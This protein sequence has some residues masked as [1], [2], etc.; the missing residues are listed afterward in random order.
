MRRR[1][2]FNILAFFSTI[3][4]IHARPVAGT[5]KGAMRA[6]TVGQSGKHLG[7]K[8][9]KLYVLFVV[10]VLIISTSC[11]LPGSNTSFT[12]TPALASIRGILWHDICKYSGGEAGAPVV[13]GQ[14]CV[15]WGATTD[16]FGPNQVQDSFE[17]G[18]AGVTLHLGSGKCPSTGLATAITN[19]SGEYRFEGLHAGTYC[20]SYSNLTDGNNAILLPGEPTFPARGDNGFFTTINLSSSEDATVNFGYA[21]QFYN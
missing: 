1:S 13:L 6:Q 20:I 4:I 16:Q 15:Q 10:T 5:L 2:D 19:A 11:N 7:G 12:P 18:W 21:W 17:S 3:S 8:M 9:K 14:G